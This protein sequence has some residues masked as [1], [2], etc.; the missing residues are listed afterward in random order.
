VADLQ[1]RGVVT[2]LH[3][4]AG[5]GLVI[6]MVGRGPR[7]RLI[8]RGTA[9]RLR[10]VDP[11]VLDGADQLYLPAVVFTED[12][13]ADTVDR[14]LGEVSER[15]ISVTLGGPSPTELDHLGPDAFREL[16][17]A[18]RPAHVVLDL[19]EHAG[20]DLDARRPVPGAEVTVVTN[21]RRPTLVIDRAG[22]ATAVEVPPVGEIVDRTGSRDG[23][24][25]GFL[26]SRRRR[27]DAIAAVHAGHRVAA[28]VLAHLGPTTG[29]TA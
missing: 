16:C 14:L 21:G 1:R 11:G 24:L 26:S 4:E 19:D 29:S 22:V 8:D 10:T 25:A 17:R 27:A 28:R 13:M 18:L 20:L 3:R 2:H 12:P 9:V 5:T 15:R 7:S 23:F 6:T